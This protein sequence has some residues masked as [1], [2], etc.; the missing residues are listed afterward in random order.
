MTVNE[1]TTMDNN[2]KKVKEKLLS[3]AKV[4]KLPKDV[5]S[6]LPFRGL[7]SSGIME[8]YPGVFTKQYHLDDVNFQMLP[9]NEQLIMYGH[10]EDLINS[11]SDEVK[12]QF[13]IF[14]HK[15]EKKKTLSNIRFMPK[16]DGLNNFRQEMT[17]VLVGQL[18]EGNNAVEQDK[19]LTVS[20][21]DRDA[22]HAAKTLLR[23]DSQVKAGTRKITGRDTEPLK[24]VERL[25]L[26]YEI[27][28]QEYDYR[29]PVINEYAKKDDDTK[30]LLTLKDLYKQGLSIKDLVSPTAF[31]F[32]PKNY[33][34][35]GDTYG[36]VLYLDHIPPELSTE[37][38]AE[39]SDLQFNLLISMNNT[40]VSQRD[41]VKLVKNR[42]ADLEGSKNEKIKN[43]ATS[44]YIGAEINPELQQAIDGAREMMDDLTKRNQ[45]MIF[46]TM[47]VC[48]FGETKEILDANTKSVTE[49][50][51][52]NFCAL[53]VVSGQQEYA[54][55]TCMPFCRDDL[56]VDRMY[57][58]ETVSVFLPYKAMEINQKNAIFYGLNGITNNPI[59]YDR[60][61]GP[62][63]NGLIFGYSG[64]GK[65]FT[66]KLE[67]ISVLLNKPNS[68]IFVIDP[69]GEYYTLCDEFDCSSH[70]ELKTGGRYFLNPLDLDLTDDESGTD[71]VATKSDFVM[72]M[73]EFMASGQPLPGSARSVVDRCVRR[74]YRPYIENIRSRTD[75]VTCD[76]SIAPTL[77]DLY[78]ELKAQKSEI[79]DLVNDYLES[80]AMGSFKTF[81]RR[82]NVKTD[83]RLVVYDMKR[84]SS[85][86][87]PLG[88][89]I[90][91]ND[92]W[93][94]MMENNR[95]GIYTWFYIDEFHLLLSTESSAAYMK[96]I[97]KMA[98]K[99]KGV[100]TGITQNT[101]EMISS[102]DA[103]AVFL[104]TSFM[105]LLFEENL[106][107]QNLQQ[108]LSLSDS[109][110]DVISAPDPGHGLIYNGRFTIPYKFE[111]PTTSPIFD[112]LQTTDQ[113]GKSSQTAA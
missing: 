110:L 32:I 17:R 11:F 35:F 86:M 14:N 23:V 48:V 98:R 79:A 65:S 104:N 93:N 68:Q 57:T 20:V 81:A 88:L 40:R 39:L 30:N 75:G 69:M 37:F 89:H 60:T 83:E 45:K 2:I 33:F 1:E 21:K 101:E 5:T 42:I 74:I 112:I 55:N 51:E 18:S 49:I 25:K 77:Q 85:G 102:P 103:R 4:E 43:Y 6:T 24:A 94:K 47:T 8:I 64:S 90:C 87:R 50:A 66:A 97:W 91:A 95:R 3:M 54:I 61:S 28:N 100:P 15:V 108:L 113:P 31:N 70:I 99:W 52:N 53:K 29:F 58:T 12:W 10:F 80:Y 16:K 13:T 36:R 92:V 84:L 46:M 73:L 26:L 111:F 22:D 9:E 105:M 56:F 63:Y 62:N 71:P 72:S 59:L 38:I 7:S 96:Q 44:G 82:S 41:S 67:M 34:Q 19:Y 109:Q 106:D 27:Y 107:R 78:S 76:P